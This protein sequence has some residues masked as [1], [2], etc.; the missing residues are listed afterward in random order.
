MNI[1]PDHPSTAI[2]SHPTT[3]SPHSTRRNKI[4][5]PNSS[6]ILLT[7][8]Y[9]NAT[10]LVSKLDILQ[11]TLHTNKIQ[12]AII[13]ETWLKTTHQADIDGYTVYRKDRLTHGGGVCIYIK[14]D[15]TSYQLTTSRLLSIHSEQIWCVLYLNGFSYLIGGIYRSCSPNLAADLESLRSTPLSP[16]SHL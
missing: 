6:P 16:L 1:P 7:C 4:P 2:S 11:H 3:L 8:L 12:I 15:L 5:T 9:T 13:T 14:S 10:S